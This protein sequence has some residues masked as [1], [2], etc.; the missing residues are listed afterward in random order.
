MSIALRSH[1]HVEAA[2]SWRATRATIAA[3]SRNAQLGDGQRRRADRQLPVPEERRRDR[4]P[5]LN[6][7][8]NVAVGPPRRL[9]AVPGAERPAARGRVRSG[10]A[11][12]LA[13]GREPVRRRAVLPA[14]RLRH[15]PRHRRQPRRQH[16]AH[17]LLVPADLH[18]A[19]RAITRCAPATTCACT[20]SS[21]RTRTGRPAS[22]PA[23]NGGAF[24]RQQDNSAAQNFQDVATLPARVP[25]RRHDRPQRHARRT[26]VVSRR[27][28]AGRLEAHEQA[29]AEPRPPLRLRSGDDGVGEPQRARLRSGRD[30]VDHQ[31]RRK[32]PTRRGP[33]VDSGV[34]VA[35]ARR[36]A[37]RVRQQPGLL[38][39]RH[40]QHPAARRVRL[41]VER[42]DGRPRRHRASTR[43]RSS[44][45][46]ASSRRATRSRRRS[47]R[48]R[49]AA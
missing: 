23:A 12:L 26:T 6:A 16:D 15:D 41:Q 45:R 25:D 17:D 42:Q 8:L 37:V 35:R 3:K 31:P 39:R 14:L 18:E 13:G 46:T 30:A 47:P 2:A 21:A 29:D 19:V 9:A 48:R 36:R 32:P 49:I 5:H 10:V 33:I 34:A 38:E 44:S 4:Q 11:R 24:T 28:R 7:E 27:L 43:C 40:E 20:T 1:D 22:T